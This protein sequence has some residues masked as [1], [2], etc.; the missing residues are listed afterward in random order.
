MSVLNQDVYLKFSVMSGC[1]ISEILINVIVISVIAVGKGVSNDCEAVVPA[2]AF[3]RTSSTYVPI[4]AIW[5]RA[6]AFLKSETY[7]SRGALTIP[8]LE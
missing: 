5:G 7:P 3:S 6:H 4:L 2:M 8:T 1:N